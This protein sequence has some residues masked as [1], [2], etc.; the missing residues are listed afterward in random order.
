MKQEKS[1]LKAKSIRLGSF[2]IR[3]ISVH[4]ILTTIHTAVDVHK[5]TV[6]D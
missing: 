5:H 2:F 3:E 6:F 1:L 4:M